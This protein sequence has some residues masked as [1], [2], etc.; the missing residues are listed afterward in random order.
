[1]ALAVLAG[2]AITVAFVLVVIDVGIR[3]AGFRPPAY[4]IAVVEYLLLYFTLFAAPYLVRQKGHVYIDALTSQLPRVLR[5]IVEKFA[6]MVCIISALTFAY[7]G[8]GLSIEAIDSG[9]FEE[10]SIDIPI[11]LLYIPM[12]GAF[13]L[14]ATEFLRYLVGIDTMY[15]DRTEAQDSV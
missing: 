4:T 9:L 15:V 13:F 6:Y 14:V 7:I 12:P 5:F 2:A 11:W 3:T 1:M 10:R 8:W